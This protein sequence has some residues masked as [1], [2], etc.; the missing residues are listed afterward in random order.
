MIINLSWRNRLRTA[1]IYGLLI[2]LSVSFLFPVIWSIS[3]SLKSLDEVYEFPPSLWIKHP[4]WGN[5][6][7]AISRLPFLR[8]ILN[9]L[10]LTFAATSGQLLTSAMVGYS[11]ARL[12]WLGRDIWFII[13]LAT[14]MLPGQVLLIPHYLINYVLGWVGTYKPLIVPGWLGGGAFFIFLFRQFFRA[15]PKSLEDSARLDGA[16]DWR[17]FWG[18]MLPLSK[19]VIVTVLLF[20]FIGHWKEFMAPLIYLSDFT[21]YPISLGLRMYQ[22]LEGSWANYLMA[23]SLVALMPLVILFFVGQRF[24]I[25]GIMLTGIK[26]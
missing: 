23:A 16:S 14:M 17:I 1:L 2:A 19:P 5:Y 13:L 18:I 9:T 25:K 4:Q 10:V 7:R 12:K 24:F 11:F 26:G 15:I 8:F 3:A 6:P 20:S 21:S 22:A